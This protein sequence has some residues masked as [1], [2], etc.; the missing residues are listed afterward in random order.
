MSAAVNNASIQG[1]SIIESLVEA[2]V[3]TVVALPDIVTCEGVLWPIAED[4]RFRLVMVCKEDEG[5]SICAALSYCKKRAVLLIQH[6]GFLDSVNSIRATAVE[7]QLP[8]VMLVG[9]QGME[10]GISMQQSRSVGIRA[11]A[12]ICN[13]LELKYEEISSEEDAARV[14]P[15]IQTAYARSQPIALFLTAAPL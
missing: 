4:S 1:G 2:D 7:Y 11:L 3:H 15:A 9:L 10:P 12:S 8:V 5:V 14:A 6:T 13:G